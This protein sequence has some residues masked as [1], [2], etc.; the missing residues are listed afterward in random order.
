[1]KMI[2]RLLFAFLL[3]LIIPSMSLAVGTVTPTTKYQSVAGSGYGLTQITLAWTADAAA[4]TVPSTDFVLCGTI[5]RMVTN[6]GTTAPT[7]SYDISLTDAD[8]IRLDATTLDNRHTTTTE[9]V[10]LNIAGSAGGFQQ[11]T[12][13]GTV[14]FAL[15]GNSVNSATGTLI[16]YLR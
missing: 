14:T 1:M 6:P 7:A 8:G 13:C 10:I 16:I 5:Q 11:M 15:S 12:H 4:G 2:K 3:C 9:Q